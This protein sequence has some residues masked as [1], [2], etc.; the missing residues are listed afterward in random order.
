MTPENKQKLKEL[1]EN[2]LVRVSVNG[3][4]GFVV[5]YGIAKR[6]GYRLVKP[7]GMGPQG[8]Q[9]VKGVFGKVWEI[10]YD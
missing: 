6:K 10:T 8:Q 4:V 7:N 1:S 2:K 3:I 5:I 9:L